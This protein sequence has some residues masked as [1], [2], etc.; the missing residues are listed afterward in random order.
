VLFRSRI[1]S[2]GTTGVKLQW[3]SFANSISGINEIQESRLKI[4]VDDN[5]MLQ[6]LCNERVLKSFVF[7]VS[8]KMLLQKDNEQEINVGGLE[9]GVYILQVKLESGNVMSSKFFINKYHLL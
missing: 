4:S 5:Q 1:T 8:G 9:K 2:T 3:L 7:D 6:I